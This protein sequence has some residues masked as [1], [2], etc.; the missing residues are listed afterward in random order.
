M[1][2]IS[3]SASFQRGV[4][5]L[6]TR[7]QV[8]VQDDINAQSNFEWRMHTNATV[9]VNG[10]S[11]TLTIGDQTLKMTIL[12]AP[13]AQLTTGPA[14]RYPTDPTPPA[15]D[16]A[17]PGVTVVIIRLAAGTHSLQ[18][19]FDPQ[20]PCMSDSDFQ[21]PPSVPINNWSLTSHQ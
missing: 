16:P 7:R 17:N 15:P 14:T 13:D 4:R 20:W 9:T 19:L 11:A 12:N 2:Q 5:L 6:N 10:Q 1:T 18:V 3:C 21:T 8:L